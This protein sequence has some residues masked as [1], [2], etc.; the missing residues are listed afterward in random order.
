MNEKKGDV[1]FR[2]VHGN[3][4][5]LSAEDISTELTEL[6]VYDNI[7]TNSSFEK[8]IC[9]YRPLNYYLLNVE[10]I[11][12]CNLKDNKIFLEK[13]LYRFFICLSINSHYAQRIYFFLRNFKI[14]EQSLYTSNIY[15]KIP[16]NLNFECI[17]NI[18][19]DTNFEFAIVSEK[20]LEKIKSYIMFIKIN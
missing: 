7:L 13:G 5:K 8:H 2:D 19:N 10:S 12:G 3:F 4:H 16:N 11:K 14:F 20:D 1:F 9:K 6:T 17:L 15:K 18:E